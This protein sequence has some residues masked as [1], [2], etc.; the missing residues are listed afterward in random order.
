MPDI[1]HKIYV[2]SILAVVLAAGCSG[3]A[4]KELPV[5]IQ[6]SLHATAS[7]NPS[8]SGRASPVVVSVYELRNSASFLAADFF[9]LFRDDRNA[10]GEDR[11]SRQEYVLQPGETRLVR[12]RSDLATRF[13]GVVVG[14]RNIE[15]SVWRSVVPI[16][17]PYQA[18]LLWSGGASPERRLLITI[19]QSAVTMVDEAA[20]SDR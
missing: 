17:A 2:L 11:I 9:S 6:F 8:V 16:P 3:A 18:G 1:Y 5:P 15:S 20:R 19:D 4:R 10:L 13:I 14:Y 7:A 12:K